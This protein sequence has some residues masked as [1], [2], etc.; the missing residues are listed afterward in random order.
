MSKKFIINETKIYLKP[1]TIVIT[2]QKLPTSL[3]ELAEKSGLVQEEDYLYAD[4][5]SK[6]KELV[7]QN[8]VNAC[9]VFECLGEHWGENAKFFDENAYIVSYQDASYWVQK[10]GCFKM[11]I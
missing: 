4:S 10:L 8:G 1:G 9:Y 11:K 2:N 5:M 6:A 7:Q 3:N